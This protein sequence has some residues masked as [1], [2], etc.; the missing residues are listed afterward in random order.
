MEQKKIE[1]KA[2]MVGIVMNVL[3][4][5]SGLIVYRITR[6]EALFIDAYYTIIALFSGLLAIFISKTSAKRTDLFP[7]GFFIL[8]PLYALLKSSLSLLLLTSSTITVSI[9]AYRY[10]VHGQGDILN[11]LPVVPY[12]LV[13]VCLCLSLSFYYKRQNKKIGGAST[14]LL[15]ESKNSL[16][17]G[18]ISAGVGVA[19]LLVFMLDADSPLGFLKYTGDFFITV[20]LV[21]ITIKEPLSIVRS[22]SIEIAGGAL[23]QGQAKKEIETCVRRHFDGENLIGDCLVYKVGMSFEVYLQL[24]SQAQRI[25][26]NQLSSKK[27][28]ILKELRQTYEFIDLNYIY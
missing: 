8:E 1:Q 10:F 6:I 15:S 28:A 19:A 2:L 17:D 16:V 4:G 14:M 18:M 21:A 22:A 20:V 3:M 7:N 26:L 9:S 12:T 23:K 13:M 24:D 25:D 5:L 27:G 11:A